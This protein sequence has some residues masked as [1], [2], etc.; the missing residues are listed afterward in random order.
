MNHTVK[1]SHLD[2]MA[3]KLSLPKIS[4][5]PDPAVEIRPVY[6]EEAVESFAYANPPVLLD[7]NLEALQ[8]L[9]AQ[10]IKPAQR[11]AVLDLYLK[12][13][14]Y[15]LNV[16]RTQD[17]AQT[18]TSVNRQRAISRRLRLNAIELAL[19]YKQALSEIV[20]RKNLFSS[21]REYRTCLQRAMLCTSQAVLHCYDEYRPTEERL[22]LETIALYKVADKDDLAEQ[23]VS[24]AVDE[25][26]FSQSI[27]GC[28]K[29]FCLTSLVD[30][31]HL[32][33]GELWTVHEAF[34][35]YANQASIVDITQ[36]KR[37]AGLFV[38]DP[39][40]DTKPT[41]LVQYK[42]TPGEHCRLLDANPILDLLR[43]RHQSGGQRDPLASHVLTAMI[44]ALGLPPKRHS[45]R[46]QSEGK[47]NVSAGLSTVHYFIG[48]SQLSKR[49]RIENADGGDVEITDVS[50]QPDSQRSSYRYEP[51]RIANEGPGGVGIL[52]ETQPATPVGVGELVGMQF[53]L[54]G[55]GEFDWAIGVVR[56]LS[57]D[58]DQEY[59]A[60]V[61]TLGELAT[62]VTAFSE[63][64]TDTITRI[65]RPTLA[66]PSMGT[67][68]GNTLIAPRGLFTRGD[69]LR[70]QTDNHSWLVEAL[71]L[72][73]GTST[74]D[75]FTYRIV[76]GG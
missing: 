23:L 13:Y 3:I 66:L 28:F 5:E 18:G 32:A 35:E 49:P 10:P 36:T 75:R 59:Q 7:Q 51:W 43:K 27:A 70:I 14:A 64:V 41:T 21:S 16:R 31:Y 62:P 4:T 24:S 38:I 61:Q 15:G 65:P 46:E 30:P 12:V 44:R 22:W 71:A 76:E 42:G 37:P 34:G 73:E 26:L 67:E 55:D 8:K 50:N 40:R 2:D 60:G 9:N 48:G 19:G 33:Y 39:T 56:W 68:P 57:I 1:S 52:R 58:G 47:V 53:P 54:R 20:V 6:V 74:Y 25:P 11:V 29:R 69:M 63:N 45:P 72:S 17:A